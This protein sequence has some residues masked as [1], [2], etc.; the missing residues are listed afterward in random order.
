MDARPAVSDDDEI[1]LLDIYDFLRDG[2]KT[3]FGVSAFGLIIGVVTAFVLPVKYQA[4]AMLDSGRV[5][6]LILGTNTGGREVSSQELDPMPVLADKMKSPG[7]YSAETVLACGM[8]DSSGARAALA[9]A[10][11]ANVPRGST[12][13]SLTY[14]TD[15]AAAA[16]VCLEAV[17]QDVIRN[18]A[19]ALDVAKS[20][21]N[22]ER[23][24]LQRQLDSLI[25]DQERLEAARRDSLLLTQEQLRQTR[26][27]LQN[28][29]NDL[30][31]RATTTDAISVMV[32]LNLRSDVQQL[33]SA[34]GALQT[35]LTAARF[36]TPTQVAALS[37]RLTNLKVAIE[38]PNTQSA[39]YVTGVSAPE[40]PV[41]PKRNL[42]IVLGL[43]IGGFVGL[44]VL[45]GQRALF[46]I[47]AHERQ[48][49]QMR[50][51]PLPD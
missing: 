27:T 32:L 12:F 13:V 4:S 23:I 51:K 10:L 2:W 47:R 42:I 34:L 39:R 49:A 35:S 48:R 15:S 20:R 44:M 17:L 6:A 43:L 38:A 28:L 45:I 29:D 18:Q 7:F 5:G 11:S 16:R 36:D 41:A 40:S 24:Q 26:A 46:H 50:V 3:L 14:Q 22:D 31:Q 25:A 9:S 19:A 30:V 21:L 33:E 8:V 37:D 1:S